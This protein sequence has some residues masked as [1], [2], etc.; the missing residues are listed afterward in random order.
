MSI[1]ESLAK[2]VLA[3][4]VFGVGLPV[5]Y[6]MSLRMW[7]ISDRLDGVVERRGAQAAAWAGF[8]AVGLMVLVAIAWITRKSLGHYLGIEVF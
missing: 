4:L 6:V 1:L 2:V 3:G 7:D 5:I 8:A